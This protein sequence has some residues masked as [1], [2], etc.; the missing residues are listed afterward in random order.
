MLD[1]LTI[2]AGIL[3]RKALAETSNL[4]MFD[5]LPNSVGIDPGNPQEDKST[6]SS[7]LIEPIVVGNGPS[8]SF[9]V[10]IMSVRDVNNAISGGTVPVMKLLLNADPNSVTFPCSSHFSPSQSTHS[11]S[12]S[13]FLFHDGQIQ[14]F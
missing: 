10:N 13:P 11:L 1:Q 14:S 6:I 7:S 5:K 9:A 4:R 8:K 2:E 3:P 12:R